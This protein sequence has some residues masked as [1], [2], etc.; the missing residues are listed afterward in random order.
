[1]CLFVVFVVLR[2][3]FGTLCVLCFYETSFAGRLFKVFCGFWSCLRFVSFVFVVVDLKCLLLLLLGFGNMLHVD[4]VFLVVFVS[5]VF[6]CALRCW[7]CLW[8]FKICFG[9]TLCSL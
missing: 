9:Y 3:P 5:C 1:M 8:G 2:F 7:F 4:N 6:G